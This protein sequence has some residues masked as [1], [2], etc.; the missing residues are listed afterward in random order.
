M[1][2]IWLLLCIAIP[3]TCITVTRPRR[4]CPQESVGAFR[5]RCPAARSYDRRPVADRPVDNTSLGRLRA[6]YEWL[7]GA[8]PP[9]RPSPGFASDS[10]TGTLH[11]G[12]PVRIGHYAIARKLGEG[13]M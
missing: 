13:G 6:L 12:L 7:T 3:P 4:H 8:P 10:M 11:P 5:Q 9:P 2:S 1:W